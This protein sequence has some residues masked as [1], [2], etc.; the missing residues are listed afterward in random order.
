M[1]EPTRKGIVGLLYKGTRYAGTVSG[2]DGTSRTSKNATKRSSKVLHSNNSL[3]I[4]NPYTALM[5]AHA[6]LF[7]FNKDM[8]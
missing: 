6:G 2:G 4:K 5:L 7:P 8:T 1:Q 3:Q